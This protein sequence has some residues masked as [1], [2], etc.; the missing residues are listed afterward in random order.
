MNEVL[1]HSAPA[2]ARELSERLGVLLNGLP[3]EL[4]A[5]FDRML[6]VEAHERPRMVLTGQY[7]SGKS[8]LVKALTDGEAEVKI[9][10]AVATDSVEVFTW[11]GLVDLVDT[12]GVQTGNDEHDELAAEALRS[13]DLVL[14]TV[15]VDLFDD[16]LIEH[17]RYVTEDLRKTPQLLVVITK[18][19]SLIAAEGV[20]AD[21]VREALGHYAG[22]VP[23]VECDAET[24][25][26]ALNEAD[27]ARASRRAEASAMN[28][29][30]LAIN[31]IARERGDLARFRA[32]LQQVALVASEALAS[33]TVD[34][35]EEAVLTV[36]A[37]QRAA[38][39]TRRGLLESALLRLEAEF[40]TSC[41]RSAERFADTVES[42]EESTTPDGSRLDLSLIHI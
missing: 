16:R 34:P 26:R 36:L 33:L 20:R 25:L 14:F 27:P 7:S 38:L 28:G 35:D 23:W 22:Q 32:P 3:A 42:I 9:D 17:L 39:T 1:Y 15:T 2:V 41:V 21:A 13:A 30:R 40:R 31:T 8:T 29:L 24:Y 37:R 11:D 10:S 4:V 18:S 6:A 12:P 5:R 19:R